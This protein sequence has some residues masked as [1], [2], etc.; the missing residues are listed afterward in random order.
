MSDPAPGDPLDAAKR[1]FDFLRAVPG[2]RRVAETNGGEYHGPCPAAG[3]GGTDRFVCWPTPRTGYPRAWCRQCHPDPMNGVD[4]L[5]WR[6]GLD[7]PAACRRLQVPAPAPTVLPR[8]V[9]HYDYQDAAGQLLYQVVRYDPKTFKQRRPDGMGGWTW[10]LG[11]VPRV[12]YRLPTLRAADPGAVV[13]LVEGEKDADTLAFLGEVATTNPHGAGSWRAEYA[14]ELAGRRVVVVP[15]ADADGAKWTAAVLAS[16]VPVARA[17]KVVALPAG[18]KDVS[19][20]LADQG[21]ADLEALAAAAPLSSPTEAVAP[22]AGNDPPADAPTAP[23]RLLT[24][25]DLAALPPPSWL[26]DGLFETGK[27]AGLYGWYG[28]GKSFLALDWALCIAAGIPWFGRATQPG[29]VVYI[30]PEGVGGL[31]KRLAAWSAARGVP[32][33]DT[34]RVL[35][36]TVNMLDPATPEKL[37]ATLV[38]YGLTPATLI[39]IDTLARSMPGGEENNQYFSLVVEHAGQVQ[40]ATS[41]AVLVVHHSGKNETAGFRGGTSFPAGADTVIGFRNDDGVITLKCEKQKD[42]EPFADSRWVL[43]PTGESC[44]LG[45]AADQPEE[46][47]ALS[48]RMRLVLEALITPVLADGA[49]A[50]DL[51][52]ATGLAPGALFW[53]LN[54]LIGRELVGKSGRKGSVGV[55]YKAKAAGYTVLGQVAPWLAILAPTHTD[56][57]E[58]QAPLTPIPTP[59]THTDS[60]A[61][62]PEAG[63]DSHDSHATHT[64]F[65]PSHTPADPTH[66]HPTPPIRVGVCESEESAAGEGDS[67]PDPLPDPSVVPPVWAAPPDT[68]PPQPAHVGVC[69][70]SSLAIGWDAATIRW[71]CRS[72]WELHRE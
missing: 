5:M 69:G 63:T 61:A 46:G 60:H 39:V 38:A 66:T 58:S 67:D 48:G 11:D 50:R 37:T 13:W 45:P 53:C 41:A 19:D 3:C 30:A 32:V 16:V 24:A 18:C 70:H 42:H 6:D 4:F 36:D 72:C 57:Y 21:L 71:R 62:S 56:S 59:L 54:R 43:V 20:F 47:E 28:G 29:P 65:T 17:C 9:A 14:A 26:I 25:A 44:V 49:S 23:Y 31:H 33:P 2:L 10:K 52:D 40:R 15:D 34:F 64:R 68:A 55:R 27:L 1:T 8:A 22:L 12:L 51:Q 7:F 35:P